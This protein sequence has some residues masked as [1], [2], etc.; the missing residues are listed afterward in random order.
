M[1]WGCQ[2]HWGHWGCWGHWGYW[3]CRCFRTG[4]SLLRTSELFR[5]LN[6]ASF[7]CFEKKCF[8]VESWNIILNFSIFSVGGCWGQP[9]SFFWQLFDETQIPKPPKATRYHKSIKLLMLPLLRADL[10]ISVHSETP[11]TVL[12]YIEMAALYQLYGCVI[13]MIQQ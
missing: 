3:G 11:C 10:L 2:G 5:H 12:Y 4:K 8:G 9:M 7:L 6:S 1:K 13:S